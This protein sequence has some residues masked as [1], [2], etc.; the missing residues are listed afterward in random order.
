MQNAQDMLR[1]AKRERRR[2]RKL[3]EHVDLTMAVISKQEWESKELGTKVVGP[4][5]VSCT[6]D[7]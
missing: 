3:T 2:A 5:L 1:D 6:S 7:L 4:G